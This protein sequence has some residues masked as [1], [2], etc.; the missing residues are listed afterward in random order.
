MHLSA[1]IGWVG[2]GDWR[3]ANDELEKITQDLRSH[4]EVLEVRWLI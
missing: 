1:A 2:L 4:P 3:E